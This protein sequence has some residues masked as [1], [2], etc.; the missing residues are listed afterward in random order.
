MKKPNGFTLIELVVV[1]VILGILAVTA[2]PKFLNLQSDAR[3]SAL[4]GLKGSINGAMG[5]VY[6]KAVIQG[7]EVSEAVAVGNIDVAWG[8]PRATQSGIAQAVEG[9]TGDNTGDW[10]ERSDDSPTP[11]KPVRYLM[12]FNAGDDLE[13]DE[14]VATSCYLQ[15]E[16]ATSIATPVLTLFK[17][18]C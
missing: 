10:S 9:L 12:T 6:G 5:I 3:V 16:E 4:N 18:G 14:I 13:I 15:Y 11:T 2:A 8:Y 17:S 7:T 1:I